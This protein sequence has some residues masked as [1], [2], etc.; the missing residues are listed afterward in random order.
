MRKPTSKRKKSNNSSKDDWWRD[1]IGAPVLV[2]IILFILALFT[3]LDY[4]KVLESVSFTNKDLIDQ[5]FDPEKI[6]IL[7][8][9]FMD[10]NG[11][12]DE[13]GKKWAAQT[14]YKLEQFMKDEPSLDEI[15]EVRRLYFTKN[16]IV[17]DGENTA[18]DIGDKVK[19]D[20]VLWGRNI[21]ESDS[22]CYYAHALITHEARVAATIQEGVVHKTQILRADLPLLVGAE[23]DVLIKFIFGWTYLTDNKFKQYQSALNYLQQA[24]T[25]VKSENRAGI[26]G[27]AIYASLRAGNYDLGFKLLKE[28][29]DLQKKS[30]DFFVLALTYRNL[31]TAYLETG[32]WHKAIDYYFKSEALVKAYRDERTLAILYND[33]ASLYSKMGNFSQALEFF[34]YAEKIMIESDDSLGL[35]TIY[36]GQGLVYRRMGDLEKA[37]NLFDKSETILVQLED[38]ASLGLVYNNIGETYHEKKELDKAHDFYFKAKV[39]FEKLGDI[40]NLAASY[41]NFGSLYS[42][43]GKYE[44]AIDSHNKSIELCEKIHNPWGVA[45][46]Y[47]NI[48]GIHSK[49]K[50]WPESIDFSRRA[51]TIFERI[52]DKVT[53][54]YTLSN[55]AKDFRRLNLADSASQYARK[56]LIVTNGLDE[57]T[58]RKNILLEDM[59]EILQMARQ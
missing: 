49:L 32:D 38:D 58:Y 53:L 34:S 51:A 48:A 50:K 16:N 39:L 36:S 23:A 45:M 56:C 46:G 40:K 7:V 19:A 20:I 15:A 41:N 2:A 57:N 44:K 43:T 12:V 4:S 3:K 37:L 9:D 27:W 47:S 54:T 13:Q 10:V 33:I 18:K 25:L 6:N 1:K 52:G 29:E 14:F 35:A 11:E 17:I 8:A 31:G 28:Q 55:I 24:L 30:S 26:L 59:N 22:I 5:P 21:C 42:Q